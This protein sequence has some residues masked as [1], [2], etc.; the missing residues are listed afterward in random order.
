MPGGRDARICL[1]VRCCRFGSVSDRPRTDKGAP[2]FD[3]GGLDAQDQARYFRFK[4]NVADPA[5]VRLG[6]VLQGR[7][8]QI[9]DI[10][11]VQEHVVPVCRRGSERPYL[12]PLYAF[13]QQRQEFCG[14]L[15]VCVQG[16][17]RNIFLHT[18]FSAG[19]GAGGRFMPKR[20]NLRSY[21]A[22]RKFGMGL[23][24]QCHARALQGGSGVFGPDRQLAETAFGSSP[25]VSEKKLAFDLSPLECVLARLEKQP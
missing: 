11:R 3:G 15:G 20:E 12:F 5:D 18:R 22:R 7:K 6:L 1:Y 25:A 17:P 13:S 8:S 9:S 24:R 19:A 23:G 16:A 21:V 14:E 2:D 4:S 10:R